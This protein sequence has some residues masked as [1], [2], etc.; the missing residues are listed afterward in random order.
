MD[1]LGRGDGRVGLGREVRD[2][3]PGKQRG[4]APVAGPSQAEVDSAVDAVVARV[5]E[6]TVELLVE[7]AGGRRGRG[8]PSIGPVL[9]GVR[10]DPETY[11]ELD[12]LAAAE[13][14]PRS[15]IVR[16]LIGEALAARRRK[17]ARR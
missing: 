2:V 8:R 4:R 17:A 5:E 10:L 14:V 13:D 3:T 16:A 11:A 7:A 1:G 9:A 6:A 15:E 12:A